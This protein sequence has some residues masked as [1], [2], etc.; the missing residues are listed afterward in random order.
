MFE[1]Q[2]AA[3]G[4]EHAPSLAQA[5]NGVGNGAKEEG[6][7]HLIEAGVPKKAGSAHQRSP[8]ARST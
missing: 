2:Q 5:L 1:E 7:H 6:G 4:S 8:I 3:S